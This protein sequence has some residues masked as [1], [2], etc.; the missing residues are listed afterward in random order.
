ML[1]M[2]Y[3]LLA[4]SFQLSVSESNIPQVRVTDLLF[5]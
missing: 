3:E 2:S 1:A 5:A 4:S